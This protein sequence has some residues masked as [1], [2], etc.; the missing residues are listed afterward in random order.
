MHTMY[1]CCFLLCHFIIYGNGNLIEAGKLYFKGEEN[2]TVVINQGRVET[3]LPK[4]YY[5][6][7]LLLDNYHKPIKV[8]VGDKKVEEKLYFVEDEVIR[9]D[10]SLLKGY[11]SIFLLLSLILINYLIYRYNHRSDNNDNDTL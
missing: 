7:F 8:Y 10:Q 3:S 1:L 9:E 2:I 4:G 11:L 6:C 5:E